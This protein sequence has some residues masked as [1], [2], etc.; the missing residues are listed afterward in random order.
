MEPNTGETSHLHVQTESEFVLRDSAR[1]CKQLFQSCLD[2]PALDEDDWLEQ[3]CAEFSWWTSGLNVDKSGPGSLDSRLRLRPDV[4]DVV[5]DLLDGLIIALSKCKEIGEHL[6][7]I[8][9]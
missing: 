9:K 7:V 3:K 4:R 5:A 2:I 1:R 6:I 8:Q